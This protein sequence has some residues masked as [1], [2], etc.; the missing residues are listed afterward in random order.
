LSSRI[1]PD[2]EFS[3]GSLAV[4]N[5]RTDEVPRPTGGAPTLVHGLLAWIPARLAALS[6]A[7]AGVWGRRRLAHLAP[8]VA[9]VG[10]L[11]GS[12]LVLAP[13]TLALEGGIALPSTPQGALVY[14]RLGFRTLTTMARWRGTGGGRGHAEASKAAIELSRPGRSRRSNAR[15]TLAQ[16]FASAPTAP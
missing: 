15:A 14:G 1:S 5:R 4:V 6:Y 8:E 2:S 10:M 7:L 3:L 16:S 9:A 13:L 12:T 11:T